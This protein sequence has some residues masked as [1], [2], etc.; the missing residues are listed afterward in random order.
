MR[1]ALSGRTP[2]ES[3]RK[4]CPGYL[5]RSPSTR[6]SPTSNSVSASA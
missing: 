2:I 3:T 4:P 1:R 5:A 6:Q